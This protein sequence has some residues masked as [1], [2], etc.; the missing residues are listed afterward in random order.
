MFNS[1]ERWL[2]ETSFLQIAEELPYRSAR[3]VDKKFGF[4]FQ[5]NLRNLFAKEFQGAFPCHLRSLRIELAAV[6]FK[7]PVTGFWV[8]MK[9][10]LQPRGLHAVLHSTDILLVL[11]FVF[12]G[13]VPE[14]IH[15]DFGILR[16]SSTVKHHD[17]ADFF[18]ALAG[19]DKRPR[20]PHR[21]A[22][23]GKCLFPHP[24]LVP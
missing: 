24:M 7:E 9:F 14:N 5:V 15:L 8:K 17:L 6:I 12:L 19:E 22:N 20:R 18:R 21:E 23:D 10:S 1:Y 16:F 11:P 3:F 2:P 13:K 4:E